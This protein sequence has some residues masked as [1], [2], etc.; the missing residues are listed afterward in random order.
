MG[1]KSSTPSPSNSETKQKLAREKFMKAHNKT[2]GGA[3]ISMAE[4]RELERKGQK[5][6]FV[7]IRT[8]A[9][10]QVSRFPKSID[11][12]EFWKN[13]KLYKDA[14]V[15]SYC[16]IGFRS[17]VF[18]QKL[19]RMGYPHIY[20]GEGVVLWT[21]DEATQ[22]V[23]REKDGSEVPVKKVHVYGNEWDL[24]ADSY[25]TVTFSTTD[26]IATGFVGTVGS[27]LKRLWR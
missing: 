3:T 21:Y 11:E 25:E 22:L 14:H 20:N 13:K 16:T 6:V 9:E 24:A 2:F 12:E 26:S 4:A 18:A 10:Q 8:R 27:M 15:V 17:G 19:K 23:H 5:V 7:D 1:G